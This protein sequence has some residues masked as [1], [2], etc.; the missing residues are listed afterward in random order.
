[1]RDLAIGFILVMFS[2]LFAGFLGYFG[3]MG[4][5]FAEVQAEN[6]KTTGDIMT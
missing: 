5:S 6:L 2:Y 4:T 3:F 1:M